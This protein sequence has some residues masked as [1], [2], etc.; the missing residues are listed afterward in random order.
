MCCVLLVIL[1]LGASFGKRE[2]RLLPT[3]PVNL[4][5]VTEVELLSE[6]LDYNCNMN[7]YK[8]GFIAILIMKYRSVSS[9]QK[10]RVL[11]HQIEQFAG[12]SLQCL[13]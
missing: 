12:I 9:Q 8:K 13:I 10:R 1:V 11:G 6:M 4:S 2:M 7:M 5:G 3:D